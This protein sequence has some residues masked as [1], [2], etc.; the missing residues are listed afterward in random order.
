[1]PIRPTRRKNRDGK[2][3]DRYQREQN[4]GQVLPYS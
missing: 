3:R 2:D 1:V 4:Q